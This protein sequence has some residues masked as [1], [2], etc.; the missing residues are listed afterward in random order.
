AAPLAAP[1]TSV[2]LTAPT[3]S[4]TAE[5]SA[6]PTPTPTLPPSVFIK[7]PFTSQFTTAAEVND[8]DHQEYCEA[9]ALLMVADYFKGDTRARIPSGEADTGM[10]QIYR[11]K[12]QTYPVSQDLPLTV[13]GSIGSQLFGLKPSV[14]PA[15]LEQ[16]QR[17]LAAGRPVII[18]VWTH[19]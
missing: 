17:S 6:V 4:P 8:P 5:P 18:P 9:A 10:A 15:D 3:A 7:V 11:V 13:I 16:I 2:V 19:V 14:A 1:N 12:R